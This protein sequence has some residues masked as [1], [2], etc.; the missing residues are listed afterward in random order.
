LT[1]AK[2]RRCG[3]QD[4]KML[5]SKDDFDIV[6]SLAAALQRHGCARGAASLSSSS[7]ACGMTQICA[8]Q[9]SHHG[10]EP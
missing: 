5:V 4:F 1:H 10:I 7:F 2:K 6:Y 9:K 8:C 3:L